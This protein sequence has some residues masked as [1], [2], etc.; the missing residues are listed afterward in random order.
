M[1]HLA[2]LK[3]IGKG[4]VDHH[5]DINEEDLVNIYS[6]IVF[7]I[8]FPLGLQRKVFSKYSVKSE[9]EDVKICGNWR[10]MIFWSIPIRTAG[11]TSIKLWTNSWISQKRKRNIWRCHIRMSRRSQWSAF[12][13]WEICRKALSWLG[14]FVSE[15]PYRIRSRLILVWPCTTSEKCDWEHD[16]WHIS[17]GRDIKA[18]YKSLYSRHMCYGTG[19]IFR[20]QTYNER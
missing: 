18:L 12:R 10:K 14:P 6:S 15:A 13:L 11:D 5:P 1:F 16:V 4:G 2:K 19:W 7:D 8:N 20:C 9:E 3:R 17:G